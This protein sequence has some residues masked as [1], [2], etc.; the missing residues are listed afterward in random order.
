MHIPFTRG[1]SR[2]TLYF[3]ACTTVIRPSPPPHL[4]SPSLLYCS[5]T[6]GN[7]DS[8]RTCT[9]RRS[10]R[11]MWYVNVHSV[12]AQQMIAVTHYWQYGCWFGVRHTT[13][14]P[15]IQKHTTDDRF[16]HPECPTTTVPNSSTSA[17]VCTT[18]SCLP[19]A[20]T[21]RP[22]AGRLA[23]WTW[24]LP[25]AVLLGAVVSVLVKAPIGPN[26]GKCDPHIVHLSNT[27]C[28]HVGHIS[29]GKNS[30]SVVGLPVACLFMLG[31][32]T[33]HGQDTRE[34]APL[35]HSDLRASTANTS[36]HAAT[37]RR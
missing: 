27:S 13:L 5:S 14:L 7:S 1:A 34:L 12:P 4:A 26:F 18:N 20:A 17:Q 6:V 33:G 11:L 30:G 23:A 21:S 22:S 2:T 32:G 9:S 25:H 15:I 16:I 10:W 31:A 36:R 37:S 35:S 19:H 3:E 28:L 8:V 29:A 24:E